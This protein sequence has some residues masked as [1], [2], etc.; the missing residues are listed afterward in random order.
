MGCNHRTIACAMSTIVAIGALYP[1]YR[2]LLSLERVSDERIAGH[3]GDT[4]M[5][6]LLLSALFLL[7]ML[8][9][10]LPIVFKLLQLSD[11]KQALGLPEGTVRAVIAMVLIALFAAAPLYLFKNMSGA[12]RTIEGLTA[13]QKQKLESDPNV[14]HPVFFE[15]KEAKSST[16]ATSS[17]F[18][19]QYRERPDPA[20]V[21]FA[22]QMLVL[23][24]TLATSVTSFYFGA[25]I[26]TSA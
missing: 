10:F 25:K 5:I 22:K 21:D 12:E 6:W 8:A 23:L 26:A 9:I 19:A 3:E 7:A 1:G 18:T 17:T 20:G 2:V 14:L 24:G 15:V 16:G 13:D 4:T 11:G